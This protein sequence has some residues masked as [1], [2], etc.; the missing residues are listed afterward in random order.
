MRVYLGVNS[1][2]RLCMLFRE[3]LREGLCGPASILS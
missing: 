3:S 1:E 2:T